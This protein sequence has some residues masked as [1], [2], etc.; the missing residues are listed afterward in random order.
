V[1]DFGIFSGK[2]VPTELITNKFNC[3]YFHITSRVTIEV[4]GPFHTHQAS[5]R[6]RLS[7]YIEYPSI[8]L[9][10]L[11]DCVLLLSIRLD[12]GNLIL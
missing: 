1:S 2:L 5:L 10:E 12:S 4:R 6:E 7:E 9:N 3:L 8:C 11:I